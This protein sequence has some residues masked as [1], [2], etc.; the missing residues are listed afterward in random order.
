MLRA[1]TCAL[2]GI[3]LMIL[4]T[5]CQTVPSE[6]QA[7]CSDLVEHDQATLDQVA[8]ELATLPR[9]SSVESLLADYG[10]TRDQIRACMEALS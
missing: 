4:M 10:L 3:A 1:V 9:G 2:F 5:G 6:V 8:R 7:L